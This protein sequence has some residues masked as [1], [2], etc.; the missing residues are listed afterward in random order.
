MKKYRTNQC[1]TEPISIKN[2]SEN[3]SYL[4]IGDW[5][6]ENGDRKLENGDRNLG[7]GDRMPENGT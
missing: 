6:P 3:Q 4:E 5:K 1:K 2:P 7:N